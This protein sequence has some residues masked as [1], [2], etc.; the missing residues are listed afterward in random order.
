MSIADIYF[1]Y[2]P[3]RL[4]RLIAFWYYCISKRLL[5]MAFRIHPLWWPLLTLA[6]PVLAPVLLVRN[7]RFRNNRDRAGQ[8][9]RER[10]DKARP[11]ELPELEYL[12]LTVLSEWATEEG[13]MG[14]PGVSYL[15]RSNQGSLLYDIG[16]GPGLVH[17]VTKLGLALEQ[18]DAL[19]ISHLHCDHMGGMKAQRTRQVMVPKELGIPVGKPCFLPDQAGAGGFSPEVVKGP[20]LL[21]GGVASTG[22]LARSLFFFGLTQEQAL[23]ARIKGK[24]LAIFTGCGH[25]TIE[26]ILEMVHRLSSEPTYAIGGG[27]H[28]PITSG[29]GRNKGIQVQMVFGTGKPPWQRVTNQDLSRT[30]KSINAA[31]PQKVLLSAHDTCDYAIKRF[32]SELSA[33]T[34][35]L[36]TGVSYRL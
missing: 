35:V 26:V 21:A 2:F 14:E 32:E 12:E 11:L 1:L 8:T 23:L 17:N 6:S 33:E 4:A 34:K 13:F 10:I 15:F 30:I 3:N 20:R 27:L 19:A 36:R 9:N 24:G 18:I 16:Y 28:F 31:R 7:R 29:R 25:P 22:P 5:K